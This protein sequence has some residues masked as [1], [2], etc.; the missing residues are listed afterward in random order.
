MRPLVALLAVF[1]AAPI[2]AQPVPPSVNYQGRL[3]DN[4]PAQTPITGVVNMTFAIW[5]SQTGGARLWLEPASGT[6]PVAANAGIFSVEMGQNGVPIPH[7]V[8]ASGA[9]R[10]L[11]LTANGET[12]APRQ[13]LTSVGYA[14]HCESAGTAATAGSVTNGVVTT[15]SYADPAWIT[16][17][18]GSKLLS[19]SVNLGTAVNGVLSVTNGGTGQSSSFTDGQLLIGRTSD[20]LLV[21]GTL[22]AGNGIQIANGA[23]AITLSTPIPTVPNVQIFTADGTWIKPAGAQIVRVVLVGAGKGG[24]SGYKSNGVSQ[25]GGSGGYGGGRT[26]IVIPA[27][28]LPDSVAVVVAPGGLGAPAKTSGTGQNLA[29]NPGATSFGSFVRIGYSEWSG[30]SGSFLNAFGAGGGGTG[31][32]STAPG[33]NGANGGS[34]SQ[35]ISTS[36]GG[37]GVSVCTGGDGAAVTVNYP[38]GGGGGAGGDGKVAGDGCPGGNGGLYGGGGGGGGSTSDSTGSSGAGGNG[39]SGIVVVF[40]Y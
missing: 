26:E 34:W 2:P 1:L 32:N 15:G 7:S 8:F 36:G 16:A 6:L 37:S 9:A 40:S 27:S 33:G 39:A 14:E 28:S 21:K 17:I 18:S 20:G 30:G 3:T 25:P 31:G 5:D 22:T 11:E 23:G 4:T 19:G 35:L 24:D 13:A 12:L 29:S 38:M 10:W